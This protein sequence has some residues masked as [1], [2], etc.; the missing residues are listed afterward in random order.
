MSDY[1]E[2]AWFYDRYWAPDA[3]TWELRILERLLLTELRPGASIL[4]ACCGAGQLVAA[5]AARGYSVTGIDLSPAMVSLAAAKVA[6]ATFREMDVRQLDNAG[7]ERFGAVVSM[8]DSLNHLLTLDD[9]GRAITAMSGCLAPGGRL[10]FDLNTK[11]GIESWGPMSHADG[12]AAFI[13]EPGLDTATRRGEF[14]FVGFRPHGS[15]WR[16]VD[17]VLCQTWFDDEDV[18]QTLQDAGF[19][20]FTAYDRAELLGKEPTGKKIVYTACKR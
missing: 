9:L 8:Y 19:E 5:L 10:V 20:S 11:L 16:R 15:A 3:L 1:D 13:V 6:T 7:L 17:A 18:R 12:E 14:R 2:F 4:D